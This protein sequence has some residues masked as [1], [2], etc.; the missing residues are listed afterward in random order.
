MADGPIAVGSLQ[1]CLLQTNDSAT[2]QKCHLIEEKNHP[3]AN[4]MFKLTKNSQRPTASG[5]FR[6][7]QIILFVKYG[8]KFLI[9]AYHCQKFHSDSVTLW[10]SSSLSK[11]KKGRF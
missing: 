7:F 5:S 8:C 2:I 6:N 9:P 1:L 11:V 4:V 10:E 3:I